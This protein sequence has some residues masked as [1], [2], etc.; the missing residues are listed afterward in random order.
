[1][2]EYSQP[3]VQYE[4]L[5]KNQFFNFFWI[6]LP[7]QG[8]QGAIQEGLEPILELKTIKKIANFQNSKNDF[9][10][11]II[12]IIFWRAIIIIITIMAAG[13]QKDEFWLYIGRL[14]HGP[15]SI[16]CI[17]NCF[18]SLAP[19]PGAQGWVPSEGPGLRLPLKPFFL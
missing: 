10:P 11:T 2:A 7:I 12:I 14:R 3:W 16:I 4:K 13:R 19:H 9:P 1:M 18:L 8:V 6:F 17:F 5:L 15:N